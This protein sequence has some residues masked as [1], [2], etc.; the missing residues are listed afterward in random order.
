MDRPPIRAATGPERRPREAGCKLDPASRGEEA[1]RRI[2]SAAI[3]EFA[4]RGYKGASTRQITTRAGVNLA[5]LAYYFG[6][7]PKLY[8]ASIDH[9]VQRLNALLEPVTR[10]AI[11]ALQGPGLPP[12][13]LRRALLAYLGELS[14]FLLGG[15]RIDW[16]PSWSLLLSRTEFEPPEGDG[17]AFRSTLGILLS[18]CLGLL[19]RVLGRSETDETC[20]IMALAVLSQV[21]M[22]RALPDG[23]LPAM[24]WKAVD[25]DRRAMIRHVLEASVSALLDAEAR[26]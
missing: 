14:A 24:G 8:R 1:R 22:F 19:A 10:D 13:E 25:A 20:R 5:A 3:E 7:K 6:G 16:Q 26:G 12:A 4:A 18:P 9:V 2:L 11:R 21:L 23:Q 17:W 15:A